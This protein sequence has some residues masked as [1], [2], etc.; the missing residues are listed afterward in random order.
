M[1]TIVT[2]TA[3]GTALT[4]SELDGNFTNLNADGIANSASIASLQTS[5][6]DTAGG[7]I[8]GA[9]SV[10]GNLTVSGKTIVAF[11]LNSQSGSSVSLT[12]PGSQIVKLTNAS[13]VSIAGIN[14]GVSGQKV[15]LLNNTGVALT[16]SN[17]DISAASNAQIYTGTGATLNFADKSSLSLIYDG[18]SAKWYTVGINVLTPQYQT[19]SLPKRSES[20]AATV[21]ALITTYSNVV[22]T[23]TVTTI[24]GAIAPVLN[25][26]GFLLIISNQSSNTIVINSESASATAENR[27]T[28]ESGFLTVY[29]NR[30]YKFAY[31]STTSRW[32]LIDEHIETLAAAYYMSTSTASTT[33]NPINFA[34]KEYDT[35]NA[36]TTGA[37]WKFTVPAGLG[38]K[39]EVTAIFNNSVGSSIWVQIYKNNSVYKYLGNISSSGYGEL[40]SDLAL[41]AG[42]YID[43]R[44][45][46]GMTSAGAAIPGASAQSQIIIKRTGL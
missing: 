35:H 34:T 3:K 6:L 24:N 29:P 20:S 26:D 21:N 11:E 43:I 39:F 7:T 33:G 22:V 36:V 13:L 27:F 2:R 30:S 16:I 41:A 42:D 37:S 9:L 4:F 5:K 32:T 40:C 12:L 8:S 45:A 25:S 23:G 19:I 10:S 15:T 14:A 18:V 46:S 38:G 17:L 1:A 31:N 44:P 28:L